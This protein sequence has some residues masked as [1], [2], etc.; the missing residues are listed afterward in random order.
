[1]KTFWPSIQDSPAMY[2][3]AFQITDRTYDT[4]FYLN[5]KLN[6]SRYE[7]SE[8]YGSRIFG[9]SDLPYHWPLTHR[10]DFASFFGRW[11][12]VQHHISKG[13]NSTQEDIE[14]VVSSAILGLA[15]LGRWRY[16]EYTKNHMNG[17]VDILRNYLPR[18]TDTNMHTSTA[19]GI[20][21]AGGQFKWSILFASVSTLMSNL[22]RCRQSDEGA[23]QEVMGLCKSLI[24]TLMKHEAGADINMLLTYELSFDIIQ[25]IRVIVKETLLAFVKRRAYW[26]LD[27]VEDIVA[28]LGDLGATDGRLFY[29]IGELSITDDTGNIMREESGIG[30]RL[31]HTQSEHLSDYFSHERLRHCR[32]STDSNRLVFERLI[33]LGMEDAMPTEPIPEAEDL[34]SLLLFRVIENCGDCEC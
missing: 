17:I 29:A 3:A 24:K 11:D 13:S 18:S 16:N 7:V 34:I 25:E 23:L 30:L 27:L 4:L 33:G 14:R 5:E 1:M 31:T 22:S 9:N 21:Q 2:S 12:Y 20:H 8:L 28:F 15:Y 19:T 10:L 32:E 26:D 6:G